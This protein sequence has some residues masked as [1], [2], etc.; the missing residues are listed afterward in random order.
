[1]SLSQHTHIHNA[2]SGHMLSIVNSME[3]ADS[4]EDG[5][6]YI[7]I[8]LFNFSYLF[9]VSADSPEKLESILD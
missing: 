4:G 1:M 2:D 7:L 9:Q 3:F 6:H 5:P 8:R